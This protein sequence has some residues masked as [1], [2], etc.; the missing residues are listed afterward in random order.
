MF[1]VLLRWFFLDA[2]PSFRNL[3][4]RYS[5]KRLSSI[6]EDFAS[7]VTL[8]ECAAEC[9]TATRFQCRSFSY[10]NERRSCF[11]YAVSLSDR[12]VLLVDADGR[13]HYESNFDYRTKFCRSTVS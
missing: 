8:D 4:T 3:F 10:D 12:D 9:V 11:L 2:T 1:V 6:Q 5:N 7:N 13:D